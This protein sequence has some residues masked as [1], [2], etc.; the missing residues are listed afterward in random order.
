MK[1]NSLLFFQHPDDFIEFFFE[2]DIYG[3]WKIQNG[4]LN[5]RG[6]QIS[7]RHYVNKLRNMF[8]EKNFFRK[9]VSVAEIVSWLDTMSIMNRLLKS[10]RLTLTLNEYK[11]INIYTEYMIEM[12]K[13]MRVD[14]ILEYKNT[15]LLLE[16]R[17]VNNFEKLRN[18]WENKF[19]ELLVYKELMGYYLPDKKIVIYAFIS[20]YEYN[21]NKKIIKHI[22]Y[23]N[24]Q[25]EYLIEYI[26][27]YLI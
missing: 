18:T 23:N 21:N 1:N 16:F 12:S 8:D 5:V 15:I 10:L 13:K 7:N 9:A 26:K 2:L 17:T 20:I 22:N 24:N 4:I 27:R 3:G 25:I 19:R 6:K 11:E 14:Y